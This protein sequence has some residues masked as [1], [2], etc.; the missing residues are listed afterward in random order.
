M[1]RT[2]LLLPALL[3]ALGAPLAAQQ[4]GRAEPELVSPLGRSFYALPDTAGAIARADA[5][6][7]ASPWSAD[8]LLAAAAARAGVWRYGEAIAL[9]TRGIERYPDDWRFHRFRGHR[10]ISTRRFDEA[11]RDLE[12]AAALDSLSFDVAYHLGLAHYLQGDFE[13]AAQV[14]GRCMDLAESEAAL[15]LERSGQL[16]QGFRS[17]MAMAAN[18]NDRV[19]MADW[20]YRALRR[21]GRHEEAARLLETIHPDMRVGSNATY[22]ETL[23]FYKGLKPEEEILDP[24]RFTGN[25]LETITYAVA[26]WH[27]IE[28]DTARAHAM[29]Q[30][31]VDEGSQ[32]SAFGYIGAETELRRMGR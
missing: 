14:Y 25:Q 28:G 29:F 9:Y 15:A 3:A 13:R 16:P 23:L 17:C 21:A 6:L 31:I 26:N 24:S 11:V 27:Q 7:A 2:L 22:L 4:A 19:A 20:R 10:Y 5:A 8:A 1:T 18:D 12:R 30:R 32:W